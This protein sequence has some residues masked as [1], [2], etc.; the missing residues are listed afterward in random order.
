MSPPDRRL[1]L[2]CRVA[3]VGLLALA[4]CGEAT[5]P[6]QDGQAAP[7]AP[8]EPGPGPEALL[9]RLLRGVAT[10]PGLGSRQLSEDAGFL[11]ALLWPD[12]AAPGAE[13]AALAHMRAT[14][15]AGSLAAELA[16]DPG[17]RAAL[18]QRD[19]F[20][21][22]VHDAWQA[23]AQRGVEAYRAW[24]ATEAPALFRQRDEELQRLFER[25]LR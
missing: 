24:C 4:A 25:P 15:V 17:A 20:G 16:A 11:R 2:R 12:L 7:R 5:P 13:P 21:L 1:P 18:A 8:S 22:S 3:L 9:A 6:P 10:G 19:P 23:A 14:L